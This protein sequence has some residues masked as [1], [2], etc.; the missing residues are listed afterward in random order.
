[1]HFN[2]IM[3]VVKYVGRVSVRGKIV[4]HVVGV[5]IYVVRTVLTW[6]V[7]FSKRRKW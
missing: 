1:M 3:Y 2:R 5:G 6:V 7:P 4:D